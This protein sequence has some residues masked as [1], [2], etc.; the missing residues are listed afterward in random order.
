MRTVTDGERRARLGRRHH[1]ARRTGSVERVAGD[2]ARYALERPDDRLP[3]GVGAG[4]TVPAR[5]PRGRLVLVARAPADARDAPDAVRRAAATSRGAMEVACART[6]AAAERRRLATM[7]ADQ[8]VTRRPERWIADTENRSSRRSPTGSARPPSSPPPSP[9]RDEA[10]VRRG[11]AVGRGGGRLDP[12]PVPARGRGEGGPRAPARRLDER[13]V[14]VGAGRPLARR[15]PRRA[16]DDDAAP[17]SSRGGCGAFGPATTTDV[18]WWTGWTARHRPRRSAPSAPSEVALE[19]GTPAFLLPDD[20]APVRAPASW[21]ALLPSL[22]PTTMGWKERAWYLGPHATDLFDR[23]G[24]AGPTIWVDGRIVGGWAQAADGADP[25]RAPR[26]RRR[27]DA[28]E[29]RRRGR[30]AGGVAGRRPV[31]HAVPDAARAA[32]RRRSPAVTIV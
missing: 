28:G 32:A 24:N 12:D 10:H 6:Y 11:D 14:P 29:D 18:R 25:D 17:P 7:L 5:R 15:R 20:L 9:A 26:G 30:A 16:A 13:A 19:D 4:R 21:V 27:A 3:V 1:L 23:N 22:D 2:L 31:P 8:G